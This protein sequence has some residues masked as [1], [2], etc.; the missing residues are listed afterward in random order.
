LFVRA[1]HPGAYGLLM[2]VPGVNVIMLLILAFGRWPIERE[3]R[4]LR[5]VA[6]AARH[7]EATGYSRVG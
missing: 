2:L 5:L 7:A 6:R 1:G 4:A 3:L